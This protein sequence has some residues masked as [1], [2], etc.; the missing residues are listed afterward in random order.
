[1]ID[2]LFY[3]NL[4]IILTFSLYPGKCIKFEV[5]YTE[6]RMT[7]EKPENLNFCAPF[8]EKILNGRNPV[9]FTKKKSEKERNKQKSKVSTVD[10]QIK[11][12]IGIKGI[13]FLGLVKSYRLI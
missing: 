2:L 5:A 6:F 4:K 9:G 1:M 11:L 7:N 12:S 10:I 8:Y 13:Q 3:V